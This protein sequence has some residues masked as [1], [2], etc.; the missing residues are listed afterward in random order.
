MSSIPKIEELVKV[1]R[2]LEKIVRH[3]VRKHSAKE[4]PERK[5]DIHDWIEK[6]PQAIIQSFD[7]KVGILMQ[8]FEKEPVATDRGAVIILRED[9]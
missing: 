4:L 8:Y 5:Q 6:H 7:G 9:I 2:D 1:Y 3:L